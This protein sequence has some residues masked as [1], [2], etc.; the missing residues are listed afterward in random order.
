MPPWLKLLLPG[1]GCAWPRTKGQ[2]SCFWRALS[3]RSACRKEFLRGAFSDHAVHRLRL[4]NRVARTHPNHTAAMR[5]KRWV[6]LA[7]SLPLLLVA[8]CIRVAVRASSARP[9][10]SGPTQ[11]GAI[12]Q[13]N[14]RL[15]IWGFGS[16]IISP[17]VFSEKPLNL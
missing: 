11:L 15:P 2:S 8:V 3:S 9:T 10:R 5:G 6:C 13:T 4:K 17:N 7:W 1:G 12:S 14:V 16:I